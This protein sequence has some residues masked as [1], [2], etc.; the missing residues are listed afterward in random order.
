MIS[1][2]S[3]STSF[4]A[5]VLAHTIQNIPIEGTVWLT[6]PLCRSLPP[7][8]ASMSSPYIRAS[9]VRIVDSWAAA[10]AGS[11]SGQFDPLDQDAPPMLP[12]CF[13]DVNFLYR[14]R[15]VAGT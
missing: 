5:P 1:D 15:S 7:C 3:K 14:G 12:S 4:R 11:F 6:L 9:H 10:T 8:H 13:I 2:A